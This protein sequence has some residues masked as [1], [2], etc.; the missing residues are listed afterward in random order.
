MRLRALP[1]SFWQQPN[2]PHKISPASLHAAK[3]LPPLFAGDVFGDVM[4]VFAVTAPNQDV[5]PPEA[6]PQT[7]LVLK[8]SNPELLF[9]LFDVIETKGKTTSVP[10]VP[11]R[12]RPRKVASSFSKVLIK[13][14]DPYLIDNVTEG[15]LPSLSLEH[16]ST[17]A[18]GMSQAKDAMA[19]AQAQM[20][21]MQVQTVAMLCM[22]EGEK[23]VTLPQ[24][25]NETNYSQML[26]DVV[27]K[28]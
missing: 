15:L 25:Q 28:M 10:H 4:D 7:R 21:Y 23:L 26:S 1:L 5:T 18:Q 17:G 12:G 6:T 14:D 19:G 11:R 22:K 2:V 24:L 8:E 27:A 16:K 13:S 3:P 20:Q 9:R